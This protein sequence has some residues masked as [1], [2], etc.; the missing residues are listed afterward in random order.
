MNKFILTGALFMSLFSFALSAQAAVHVRSYV[1][2]PT[3][4]YVSSYH[5]TNPNH[6]KKIGT[7]NVYSW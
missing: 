4:T 5:R 2:K 6:T 3:Y 1:K 7:K